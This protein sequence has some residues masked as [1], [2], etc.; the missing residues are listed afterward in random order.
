MAML[1]VALFVTTGCSNPLGIGSE[2]SSGRGT[3]NPIPMATIQIELVQPE[4]EETDS[5]GFAPQSNP[6]QSDDDNSFYLRLEQVGSSSAAIL[7]KRYY[8]GETDT[9]T[10]EVEPGTTWAIE[11]SIR[12]ASGDR[13][14]RW[15]VVARKE[16]TVDAGDSRDIVVMAANAAPASEESES[17]AVVL[18]VS[19]PRVVN[20][21]AAA[22]SGRGATEAAYDEADALTDA[23]AAAKTSDRIWVRAGSYSGFI[24]ETSESQEPLTDIRLEGPN[25]GLPWDAS[26]HPE[27]VINGLVELKAKG[28]KLDGF[29]LDAGVSVHADEVAVESVL[30]D[31][32]SLAIHP[33]V[34]KAGQTD[35]A[36][37]TLV[38]SGGLSGAGHVL[39]IVENGDERLRESLGN[40]SSFEVNGKVRRIELPEE[41]GGGFHWILQSL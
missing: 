25:A 3:E 5:Q 19:L 24:V 10:A 9:I 6:A 32:E 12:D 8:L 23:L 28:A 30:F 4:S 40:G 15:L 39:R 33:V 14:D 27:A 1:L 34:V 22:D 20:L 18:A 36:E 11:A 31:M 41:Y 38:Q 35:V 26:R 29:R 21:T 13:E 37:L 17:A 16:I 7:D 2:G